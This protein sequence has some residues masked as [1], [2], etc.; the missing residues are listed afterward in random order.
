MGIFNFRKELKIQEKEIETG[1][2]IIDNVIRL[3]AS[4]NLPRII[5]NK[6]KEWV[7]YG[8]DNNYPNFLETLFNSSPTHQAIVNSKALITAGDSIT[9]NENKVMLEQNNLLNQM[10][11]FIDGKMTL[12]E[13]IQLIALDSEL[14]GAFAL[15]LIWSIDKTKIV[16]VERISPKHIRSGKFEDGKIKE[17][18]YS[19]NWSDRKEEI[20]QI[21]AF[22]TNDKENLRQLLYVPIA[23]ITNEYYGE[24]SYLASINWISLESQ[25]GEYYKSLLDNNFSPSMIVKFFRK[26][27][28][29]EEKDMIVSGLKESFGGT[30]N[31]GKVIVS[32]SSDKDSAPEITPIDVSNVDKQFLVLSDQIQSKILT[33]GRITT[34]ELLGIAIPGSLGGADFAS[35]VEAFQKFVIRPTQKKIEIILNKIFIINGLDINIEIKPYILTANK[36]DETSSIASP[37]QSET[38]IDIEAQAKASLKGSVGGVQGIL[39]IQQSVAAGTTDYLSALAILDLIYGISEIEARRILGSPLNNTQNNTII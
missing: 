14:Y 13:L 31:A 29:N 25:C 23:L 34:P 10:I 11:Y 32:F 38:V 26:P 3:A 22:D 5:E 17:Y 12:E 4:S 2:T 15:Q 33:G 30:K 24:V 28:N 21:A 18:F 37:V 16:S 7:E 36:V 35:Q 39:S 20:S 8:N 19:R 6:N 9:F 27:A 1:A